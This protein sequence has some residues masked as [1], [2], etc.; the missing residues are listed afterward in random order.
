MVPLGSDRIRR[1]QRER[2]KR[3]AELESDV[4]MLRNLLALSPFSGP[5]RYQIPRISPARVALKPPLT[6]IPRQRSSGVD[7]P[8]APA[9]AARAHHARRLTTGWPKLEAS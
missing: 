5:V 6:N 8:A 2:S 1:Q 4:R 3:I 7:H 9:L